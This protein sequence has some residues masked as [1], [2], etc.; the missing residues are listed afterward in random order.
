[1]AAERDTELLV[2]QSAPQDGLGHGRRGL[3][4]GSARGEQGKTMARG[5]RAQK[6]LLSPAERLG[7]AS[8]RAGFVP[9][10]HR[11]SPTRTGLARSVRGPGKAQPRAGLRRQR[12][13]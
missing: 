9:G 8:H 12:A 3:H 1:L 4:H 2:H 5:T 10:P 6:D 13:P 7:V 11:E